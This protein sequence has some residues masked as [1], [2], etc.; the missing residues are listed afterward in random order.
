MKFT[1]GPWEI[2]LAGT[3]NKGDLI[4][5]YYGPRG[6]ITGTSHICR[7]YDTAL[8]EEHGDTMSNARLI[9]AAPELLEALIQAELALSGALCSCTEDRDCQRCHAWRKTRAAIAKAEG[10]TLGTT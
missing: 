10:R 5:K 8:C 1:P 7:L 2:H 6:S 4:I 9:A 3:S